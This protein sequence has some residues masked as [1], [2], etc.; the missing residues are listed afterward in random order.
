MSQRVTYYAAAPFALRDEV[1]L[2]E[3]MAV[4]CESAEKAVAMAHLMSY[5]PGYV[6]AWAYSRTG[7]PATGWYEPAEVLRRFGGV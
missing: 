7:D 1:V 4:E 5:M 6:G 2:V 3:D